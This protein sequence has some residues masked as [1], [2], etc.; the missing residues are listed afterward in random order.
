MRNLDKKIEVEQKAKIEEEKGGDGSK[1][2][3]IEIYCTM[4][5]SVLPPEIRVHG[6]TEVPPYF[7]A[8]FSCLYREYKYFFNL[9]SMDLDKMKQ[10]AEKLVGVHD[11]RNF[12]KKDDSSIL[13]DD[14][15]Q[16]F[17]RRIFCIDFKPVFGEEG[18]HS[19][20]LLNMYV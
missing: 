13:D 7:D 15:E 8:R 9:K 12:C 4:M 20:P 18:R 10:A 19:H 14:E 17:M 16:N 5:N 2:D 1:R 11:F 6:Y 3:E